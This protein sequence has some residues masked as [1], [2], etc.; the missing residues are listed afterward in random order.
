MI[1]IN[2]LGNAIVEQVVDII[3][4]ASWVIP[5]FFLIKNILAYFT[6]P[7]KSQQYEA[8]RKLIQSSIFTGIFIAIAI[9]FNIFVKPQLF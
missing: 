3:L 2:F 9:I 5:A 1:L 6:A 7:G 8:L 4:L